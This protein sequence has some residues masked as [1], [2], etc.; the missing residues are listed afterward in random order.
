MP[1]QLATPIAVGDLDPNGPYT[2]VRIVRQAHDSIRKLV[3]VDLE[4]GNLV[5][6]VWTSGLRVRSRPKTIYIQG[7]EYA[8]LVA[9]SNPAN[10]EGT[11]DAVKRGLYEFLASKNL[12]GPG[13]LV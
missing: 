7:T 5:D 4:Y 3:V 1:W 10:G 11:Y 12:I 9:N 6:G 2:Q 13:T 8:A